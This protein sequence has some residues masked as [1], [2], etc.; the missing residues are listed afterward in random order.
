MKIKM[1]AM[2]LIIFAVI[3][4]GIAATAAANIWT[5]ESSKIP[6]TYKS[7]E[8]EGQYNPK[9]IR[10]SYTFKEVSDLFNIELNVLYKAFIIPEGTDSSI[11]T[12]ELESMYEGMDVEIG[13]ESMQVFVAL[14]KNLPVILDDVYLPKQA[15]EIIMEANRNLTDE[16]RSYLKE[17]QAE[18][19]D[20]KNETSIQ[21]ETGSSEDPEGEQLINGSTT[22]QQAIDAGIPEQKIKDIIGKELPSL[23][24]SI[25]SFCTQEGLSFSEIKGKLNE[26]IKR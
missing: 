5:T 26:S 25:K 20:V 2:A 15:V 8:Y 19:P 14:Y 22:F 3:F 11:K 12:K 21:S 13:N 4:G 16:Q 17:Y 10:G 7:G 9:D 23:N 1:N 18:I 6:V 24:T